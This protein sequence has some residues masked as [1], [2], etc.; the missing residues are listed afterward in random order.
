MKSKFTKNKITSTH[1]MASYQPKFWLQSKSKFF[2]SPQIVLRLATQNAC[3]V[4][5]IKI[6]ESQELLPQKLQKSGQKSLRLTVFTHYWE[7]WLIQRSIRRKVWY[8]RSWRGLSQNSAI[9]LGKLTRKTTPR[10]NFSTRKWKI[11]SKERR[12]FKKNFSKASKMKRNTNTC[13]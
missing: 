4:E 11:T 12:K 3:V 7:S 9:L 2:V 1:T 10:S 5:V 13:Y 8:C 6:S